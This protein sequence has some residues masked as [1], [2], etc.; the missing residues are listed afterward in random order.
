MATRRFMAR[1]SLDNKATGWA[2][3][4]K[5]NYSTPP[6]CARIVRC[7]V[8]FVPRAT[9]RWAWVVSPHELLVTTSRYAPRAAPCQLAGAAR[10]ARGQHRLGTGGCRDAVGA[11]K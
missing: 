8:P 5:A 2:C 11:G 3:A 7:R 10:P 9:Q 1:A 4:V 6:H